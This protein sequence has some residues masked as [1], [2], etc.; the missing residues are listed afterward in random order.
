MEILRVLS[1]D[2]FSFRILNYLILTF[3]GWDTVNMRKLTI[4]HI[5]KIILLLTYYFSG[6]FVIMIIF[7][8]KEINL[9]RIYLTNT[10]LFSAV[11]KA[12]KFIRHFPFYLY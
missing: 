11:I 1:W 9:L 12:V 4:S 10:N 5:T 3:F 8:C 7:T 2:L 6:L